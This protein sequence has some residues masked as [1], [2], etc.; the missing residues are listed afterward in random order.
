MIARSACSGCHDDFYNGRTNCDGGDRCW[1]AKAGVM[2]TRYRIHYMTAPTQKGAFAKVRVPSCYRQVNSY[3]FYDAL[4][5]FVKA[6]DL[7][8][9]RRVSR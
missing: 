6:S 5:S 3:V 4:P 9:E 8:R 1:S 2:K 7:N